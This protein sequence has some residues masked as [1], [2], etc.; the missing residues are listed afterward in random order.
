MTSEPETYDPCSDA[1]QRG[2]VALW[3]AR[4]IGCARLAASG[5]PDAVAFLASGGFVEECEQIGWIP[6]L[7]DADGRL[8]PGAIEVVR[9]NAERLFGKRD[10]RDGVTLPCPQRANTGG[11]ARMSDERI[12]AAVRDWTHAEGYAPRTVD[13]AAATGYAYAGALARKLLAL[14]RAG[15][16]RNIGGRKCKAWQVCEA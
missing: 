1:G 2:V 13:V 11:W 7:A 9:A 15:K 10:A 14:E 12:V 4:L 16:L 6:R 3:A 5:D 8:K